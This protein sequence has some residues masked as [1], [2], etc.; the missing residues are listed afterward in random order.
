MSRASPPPGTGAT[1]NELRANARRVALRATL[2]ALVGGV[3]I[4]AIADIVAVQRVSRS[5]DAALSR[6]ITDLETQS[7]PSLATFVSHYR[8][9]PSS[10]VPDFDASTFLEWIVPSGST[11]A[12]RLNDGTP[13]LP[14]GDRGLSH[15]QSATIE[16]R[17]YLL[18]GTTLSGGHL[19]VGESTADDGDV[20]STL[21][22]VQS[23]LAPLAL[24]ALYLVAT[25]IGRRAAAPIDRARRR[26]LDFAADA[27]HELRTPLS[28]I[29]AEVSLA[30]SATRSADQYRDALE[31]VSAETGRLR[32]IVDDLLWLARLDSIPEGSEHELVDVAIIAANCVDRFGAVAASRDITLGFVRDGSL[33]PLV[34]A[35]A[36][37]L[38]ELV[39]VLLDNATRHA[40]ARVDV[41][42]SATGPRVS[43]SV[44][45][46][47]PGFG[48]GDHE[49][50]LQRFHRAST[51]P[52]GAGLGLAIAGAVV[53]ATKGEI[54]LGTSEWG[55]AR[56]SVSWP[57]RPVETGLSAPELRT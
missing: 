32:K 46:D 26:Q 43:V 21:L 5:L 38:D 56:V 47:G 51:E 18:E 34:M 40:R 20:L 9:T 52:G 16:G 50:L 30:L 15:L 2:V 17:P 7:S 8:H 4:C 57:R 54:D 14:K 11:T 31:R 10:D 22:V 49:R 23:I 24:L 25:T 28:V 36:E 33:E 1:T 35:P 55:G 42:V 3:L 19:I 37:W 53:S 48:A 44:D 27:S 13:S 45:D 12:L 41:R 6:R 39:S 29:Q